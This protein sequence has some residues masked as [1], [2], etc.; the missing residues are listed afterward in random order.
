M[1]DGMTTFDFVMVYLLHLSTAVLLTALACGMWSLGKRLL[2]LV[3]WLMDEVPAACRRAW[4]IARGRRVVVHMGY[5]GYCRERLL[6]G[7][8][9]CDAYG[10]RR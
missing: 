5:W 8:E 9:A 4:R 10:R 7:W 1:A 6:G 2:R 3:F